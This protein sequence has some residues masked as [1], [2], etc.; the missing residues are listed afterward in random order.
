MSDEVKTDETVER[1]THALIFELEYIAAKKRHVEFEALKIAAK[2]KGVELT[3][4]LFSRS[5]M[6]PL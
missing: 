1:A 2:T 5:G 6:R 4:V 3:P